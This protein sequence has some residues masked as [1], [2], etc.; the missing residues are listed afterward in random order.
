MVKLTL[1]RHTL[2]GKGR[3]GK[4]RLL[5]EDKVVY[6]CD[7]LEEVKVGTKANSDLAVP[8]GIYRLKEHISQKYSG[9]VKYKG[10]LLCLYNELVSANRT[11]LIHNGNNLSHTLGCVLIGVVDKA[12]SGVYSSVQTNEKF[13]T[14][15]WDL[16][17]KKGLKAEDVKLYITSEC[18]DEIS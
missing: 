18:E 10:K 6:E 4:F 2:N 5:D 13:Y 9:C 12:L 8:C 11:I 7:S 15:F 1:H 3:F 16:L 17:D 14:I